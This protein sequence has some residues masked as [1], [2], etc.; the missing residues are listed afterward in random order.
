MA[1]KAAPKKKVTKAQ[2][3]ATLD[4]AFKMIEAVVAAASGIATAG[5]DGTVDR[6]GLAVGK[7]GSCGC[8]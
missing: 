8:T 2:M 3:R 1:K 6:G 5:Q 7:K 4:N